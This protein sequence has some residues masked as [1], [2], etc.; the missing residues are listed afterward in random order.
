ME[1]QGGSIGVESRAG[2]GS[3][4]TVRLRLAGG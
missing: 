2:Q 1:A 4:F 3:V